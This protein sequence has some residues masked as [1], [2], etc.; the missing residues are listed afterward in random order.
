VK[1]HAV[2]L[3]YCGSMFAAFATAAHFCIS[4]RMCF[5]NSA[6][7]L[8]PGSIL[9]RT[10]TGKCSVPRAI[11]GRRASSSSAL[12]RLA[13]GQLFYSLHLTPDRLEVRSHGLTQRGKPYPRSTFKQ[14]SAKLSFQASYRD[15]Q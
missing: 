12:A 15:R 4:S 5:A 6:G 2:S 9:G 10:V 3:S 11:R 1:W 13:A 14:G 8:Q 7:V